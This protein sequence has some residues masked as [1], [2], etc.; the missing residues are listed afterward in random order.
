MFAIMQL[1]GARAHRRREQLGKQGYSVS[2]PQAKRVALVEAETGPEALASFVQERYVS[3]RN[4]QYRGHEI[5][6]TKKRPVAE[7]TLQNGT[8]WTNARTG[9]IFVNRHVA[10]FE[11]W[12]HDGRWN[13]K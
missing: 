11:A 13:R 10:K 9:E 4:R 2:S 3:T 8:E 12:P 6:G 1:P 5:G 7:V